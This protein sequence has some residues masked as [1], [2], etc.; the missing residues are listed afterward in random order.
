VAGMLGVPPADWTQVLIRGIEEVGELVHWLGHSR[1]AAHVIRS[2]SRR[3]VDA[4]LLA[5][6]GG[7]RAP[8][9]IPWDLQMQWKLRASERP[10]PMV[11]R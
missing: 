1:E 9:T 3:F 2:M 10:A 6:R 4:L 8:F 7:A 5:E 11:Q